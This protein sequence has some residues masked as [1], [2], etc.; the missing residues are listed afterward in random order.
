MSAWT[1]QALP[2][3]LLMIFL[4]LSPSQLRAQGLPV[5]TG[6]HIPV[7]LWFAG[8]GILGLVLIY[9]IWRNRGRTRAQKQMTEQATKELYSGTERDRRRSGDP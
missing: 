9:G 4:T 6:S 7:A 5:D 1:R 2:E 8:A 3:L